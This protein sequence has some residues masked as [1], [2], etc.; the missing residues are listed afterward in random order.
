MRVLKSISRY[1]ARNQDLNFAIILRLLFIRLG[2]RFIPLKKT[3]GRRKE[4]KCVRFRSG[5][6]PRRY[7]LLLK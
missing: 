2:S 1:E 4:S 7:L 6:N 5:I 3:H